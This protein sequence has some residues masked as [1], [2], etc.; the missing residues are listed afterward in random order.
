M[1]AMKQSTKYVVESGRP[2]PTGQSDR[3]PFLTMR[4]HQSFDEPDDARVRTLRSMATYW[5]QRTKMRFTVRRLKGG[6][7]RCW[8][9][10]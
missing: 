5:H 7:A 8:R 2:L 3:Y 10:K 6:G 4:V 9:V 1:E